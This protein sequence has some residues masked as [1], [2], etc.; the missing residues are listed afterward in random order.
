M[1][2]RGTTSFAILVGCV[3]SACARSHGEIAPVPVPPQAFAAADCR[4]LSLMRAKAERSL[5][6]SEIVQD[7]RYAEDRTRTFGVPTPMATI[8]EENREAEVARLKGEAYAIA[9]EIQRT[10][11]VAQEG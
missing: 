1:L 3:L 8:F 11:C 10:G 9:A 6:L 5:I 4:Q 2:R 7:H